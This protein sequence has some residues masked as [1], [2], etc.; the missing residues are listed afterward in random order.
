MEG[1]MP[2]DSDSMK[3][4]TGDA[5]KVNKDLIT[6]ESDDIYERLAYSYGMA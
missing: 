4:F 3:Y 1:A 2:V 5:S 6:L